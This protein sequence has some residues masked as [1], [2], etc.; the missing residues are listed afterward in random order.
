MKF[1]FAGIFNDAHGAAVI[2]YDEAIEKE[3]RLGH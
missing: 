1:E 2:K 3:E